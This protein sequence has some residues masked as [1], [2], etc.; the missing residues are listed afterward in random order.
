MKRATSLILLAILLVLPAATEPQDGRVITITAGTA[1]RL[2]LNPSTRDPVRANSLF[3]QALHV[4]SG[5]GG[6]IYVLNADPS[7]TCTKGAAGTTLVAE[8]SPATTA[9]PG[10]SFSFPSNG[11]ATTQSGGTDIRRFCLDGAQSG[12][13]VVTS[14]D[15]R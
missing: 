13:T 6:I 8:L 7:I 10:G 11:S 5:T 15:L 9:A 1:I 2:I 4:A 3:I 14:W 12:D